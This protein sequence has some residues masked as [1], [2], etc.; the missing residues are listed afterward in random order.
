MWHARSRIAKWAG[1]RSSVGT[2]DRRARLEVLENRCL[3]SATI[4]HAP[5]SAAALPEIPELDAD[6]NGFSRDEFDATGTFTGELRLRRRDSEGR[7]V[8][9]LTLNIDSQDD[10]GNVAGTLN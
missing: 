9:A 4:T 2:V 7:R 6:D 5:V 10:F 1:R 3:L 8:Y